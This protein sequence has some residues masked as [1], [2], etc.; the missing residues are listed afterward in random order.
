MQHTVEDYESLRPGWY[1]RLS[2]H[3]PGPGHFEV[4]HRVVLSLSLSLF[5]FFSEKKRKPIMCLSF[6]HLKTFPLPISCISKIKPGAVLV[7]QAHTTLQG[8]KSPSQD[9]SQ[10]Y[11]DGHIP[12]PGWRDQVTDDWTDR[13]Q[14]HKVA[15][16]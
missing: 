5:F 11:F 2:N 10:M 14:E 3:T 13:V 4:W 9:P 1:R 16:E 12:I 15:N 6:A 7:A 8:R